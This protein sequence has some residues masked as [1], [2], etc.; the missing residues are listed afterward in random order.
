MSDFSEIL[1]ANRLLQENQRNSNQISKLVKLDPVVEK[2][3]AQLLQRSQVG[4][5]KYGVG[6]DREDLNT[7]QWID[8]AIEEALDLVLYLTRLKEKLP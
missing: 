8:H 7:Q 4:L 6:L 2:V 3:R 1:K 5:K